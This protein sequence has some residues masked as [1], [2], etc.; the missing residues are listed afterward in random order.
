VGE[1]EKMAAKRRKR[2]RRHQKSV[3]VGGSI[4]NGEKAA[5]TAAAKC[6]KAA[7]AA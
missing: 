6:Q 5:I 1:Y 7:K 2:R 4:I 3:N